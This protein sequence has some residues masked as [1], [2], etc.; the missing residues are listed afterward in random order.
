MGID[1]AQI[2]GTTRSQ[3]LPIIVPER[4]LPV[5]HATMLHIAVL[6]VKHTIDVQHGRMIAAT[7]PY[8]A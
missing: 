8:V 2:E 6:S 4:A 5:L 3:L 7:V 1:A